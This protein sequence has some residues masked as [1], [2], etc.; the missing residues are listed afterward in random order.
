M[1]EKQIR[2]GPGTWAHPGV[3]G[4]AG[5][6]L[7][8]CPGSAA[9]GRALVTLRLSLPEGALIGPPWSHD[10]SGGGRAGH[11][12]LR[13]RG[14]AHGGDGSCLQESQGA[15]TKGRKGEIEQQINNQCPLDTHPT[16][17]MRKLSPPGVKSF[18]QRHTLRA[19]LRLRLYSLC[20]KVQVLPLH[21]RQ[22]SPVPT[23]ANGTDLAPEARPC[24][25]FPSGHWSSESYGFS[26]FSCILT[27]DGN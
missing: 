7:E 2:R 4:K 22:V 1:L 21:Y 26:K 24:L 6:T 14:T 23:P 18:S 5:L 19:E 27:P 12:D 13:P 16:L 3:C 20:S 11:L 17:Q 25:R 15:V 10:H 8:S 9:R